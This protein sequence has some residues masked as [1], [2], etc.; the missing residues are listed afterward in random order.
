MNVSSDLQ[1]VRGGRGIWLALAAAL[2]LLITEPRVV[3][4]CGCLSPPA[5]TEGEYAVNQRAEQI[6]FEVEPG[7]VT[8]HVLIKYAGS[9]ESFAWLIP[10]P[11]VPELAISP[12]SAFGLLDK[13]TAPDVSVSVENICP[14]SA[15]ACKYHDA[16]SCGSRDDYGAGNPTTSLDAASGGD[17]TGT[18][19][20]EVISEQIVGDYQTVTFRANEAQA[21]TQ[22]L[23]DN[24]FIV[25]STT[26]IYM[27]P[28]VQANMVFVA[29]KL[30]PGAG[31]AAIKP[32]RMRYR[33]AF[34][35]IPLLL[36]AVAADPHLTVT[37][38]LYGDQAF[39]P[40]GH[41]VISIDPKRIAQ[42]ST[43]RLNYPMVLSRAV[44]EA[45]GDGFAIEYRGDSVTPSFGQSNCCNGGGYDFC[46]IGNNNKCECPLADFDRADCEA[47]AGDLIEG[48]ALLE[49]LAQHHTTLTRIT[50]RI[51]PEEMRFDP[52]YER[53]FNA[54]RTGRLVVRGTQPS[55]AAC[56][57]A[58]IE[59]AHYDTVEALSECSSMYCGVGGQCVTTDAGPACAC[60]P[61]TVAQRFIDLDNKPSVT[62]VPTTPTCD[63]R[64]GGQVLQN[65]CA[66]VSCGAGLCEDRNGVP[67]CVCNTGMAAI[68]GTGTAPRCEQVELKSQSPGATDFSE[69]LRDIDVCAPP[70]PSCG[71]DGWLVHTGTAR[72]GVDCGGTKPALAL[73]WPPPKPQCNDL[74]GF[75]CGGG[76]QQGSSA[77]VPAVGLAWVVGALL[78][79]RRRRSR[80]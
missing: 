40:M 80:G 75:G 68:A 43:G 14:V 79:R 78:V 13:A 27:E 29:A 5:V 2:G 34:P 12:T 58:V 66:G 30:V 6:I 4:A 42:D 31:V 7:W 60:N 22:W 33:A 35:M 25:N 67:V 15:W 77:P 17:G 8:A 76:C 69:P 70:P 46:N 11:E 59:R 72:A 32:L 57:S 64:A 10:V 44:D 28:Y 56:E 50:T 41:P 45:G 26:S 1:G 21:A 20:V 65:A 52:T 73:T 48:I 16:P 37:A 54:P 24:G 61:G 55:L 62:C 39:R 47:Q 71:P 18:P 49:D 74:F 36:T 9:P 38:F 63:L 23:R 53:E 51:S 3:D 19:P